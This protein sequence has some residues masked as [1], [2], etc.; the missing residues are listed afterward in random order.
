MSAKKNTASGLRLV[1]F[2]PSVLGKAGTT[3]LRPVLAR[4]W[5][6]PYSTRATASR[7]PYGPRALRRIV[8]TG[9]R[10]IVIGRRRGESALQSGGRR[11]RQSFGAGTGFRTALRA[12]AAVA[13]VAVVAAACGGRDAVPASSGPGPLRLANTVAEGFTYSLLDL[14]SC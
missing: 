3:P 6:G 1:I 2:P 13:T 12:G 14:S 10:L 5:S 8:F 11:V 4:E 7:F 9:A